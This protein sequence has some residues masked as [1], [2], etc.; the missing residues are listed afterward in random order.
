LH[1]CKIW[2]VYHLM[3]IQTIDMTCIRSILLNI[4]IM[5]NS[6]CHFYRWLFLFHFVHVYIVIILTTICVVFASL[7]YFHL[8][9]QWVI[10]LL[11][12]GIDSAFWASIIVILF[13]HNIFFSLCN[14]NVFHFIL[15]VVNLR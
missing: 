12:Y 9:F 1:L 13:S 14:C 5:I 10:V 7:S 11:I 8:W 15:I 3:S 6:L 4:L 2:I